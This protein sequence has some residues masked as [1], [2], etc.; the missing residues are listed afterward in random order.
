[1]PENVRYHGPPRDP[2][3]VI[4]AAL[5]DPEFVRQIL[6]SYEAQLQGELGTPLKEIQS[7]ERR[8]ARSA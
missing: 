4:H 7:Q 1:M 6:S 3:A 8:G 2:A 5:T